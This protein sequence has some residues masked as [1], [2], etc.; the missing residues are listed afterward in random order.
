MIYV[1]GRPVQ[2]D[3]LKQL[4]HLARDA[5][6]LVQRLAWVTQL[7]V[8]KDIIPGSVRQPHVPPH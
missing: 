1:C 7:A 2:V 3:L 4:Q 6:L 8:F 5:D